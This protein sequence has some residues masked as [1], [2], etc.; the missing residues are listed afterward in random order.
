MSQVTIYLDPDTDRRL[1]AAVK[2]AGISRSKWIAELIRREVAEEWPPAIRALAGAWPDLPEQEDLRKTQ[3][4]DV[5][6][7]LF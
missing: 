5:P 3:G 4:S 1:Q 6:R 2:A 7:E